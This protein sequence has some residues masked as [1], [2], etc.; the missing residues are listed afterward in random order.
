MPFLQVGHSTR[1]YNNMPRGYKK[2]GT[3]C[4]SFPK[5]KD[6]PAYGQNQTGENNFAWKGNN[7]TKRGKHKWIDLQKGKPMKCEICGT[8]TAKR[9][10]WANID[11]KYSRN[12]EDYIRMCRKCHFAY[13]LKINN[14]TCFLNV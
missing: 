14:K 7:A 12:L 2:D 8:T 3:P 9:Y 11:H 13:D 4:H 1:V 10:D 6:N 5:G